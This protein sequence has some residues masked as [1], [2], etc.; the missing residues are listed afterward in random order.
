[1]LNSIINVT[2]NKVIEKNIILIIC[3]MEFKIQEFLIKVFMPII[4]KLYK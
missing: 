4:K 1:M 3:G 2:L